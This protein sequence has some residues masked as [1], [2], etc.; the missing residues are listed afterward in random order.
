MRDR[1]MWAHCVG[2]F[3]LTGITMHFLAKDCVWYMHLRHKFLSETTARQRT[4]L[5]EKVPF[6]LRSSKKL[7]TYF[8][9]IYPGKVIGSVSVRR[10]ADVDAVLEQRQAAVARHDRCVLRRVSQKNAKMEYG[11]GEPSCLGRKLPAC[12][13]H[14]LLED[15]FDPTFYGSKSLAERTAT[16]A[17]TIRKCDETIDRLRARHAKLDA[18]V[19]RDSASAAADGAAAAAKAASKGLIVDRLPDVVSRNPF[20]DDVRN[21][22]VDS[23]F[24]TGDSMIDDEIDFGALKTAAPL[25]QR[26]LPKSLGGRDADSTV[27]EARGLLR[28]PSGHKFDEKALW[29]TVGDKAFVTFSS[30][31]AAAV[32]TQ[33]FHAAPPG[34]MVATMAPEARD[35]CWR[36]V[37]AVVN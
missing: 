29:K 22:L 11:G 28:P 26:L 19:G 30:F 1:R 24:M 17:A 18:L 2:A 27:E 32:A 25:W 36:N 21:P 3:L 20:D 4:I 37:S 9:K 35:V 33:V 23:A 13:P 16:H 14:R 34:K 31:A 15:V 8:G 7:A 6:E 12:D 5:V 10:V